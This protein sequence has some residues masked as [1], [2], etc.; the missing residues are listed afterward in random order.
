MELIGITFIDCKPYLTQ[1]LF[2]IIVFILT[3][4]VLILIKKPVVKLIIATIL[5]LFQA[6]MNIGFVFLFDSNGTFFEWSMFNQRNDAFGTVEDLSLRPELIIFCSCVVIAFL[7][8][9]ILIT[10]LK[11]PKKYKYKPKKVRA[12]ITTILLILCSASTIAIPTIEAFRYSKMNYVDR[13]LYGDATNRYQQVG[14]TSNAIYELI[15][16]TMIDGLIKH[17]SKGIENFIYENNQPLLQNSEY[18]GISKNNNLVYILVES[19][20]WYVFLNKCTPEQSA[21]LYPNINKFLSESVYANNFYAREKT[22]TS[23]LLSILGSN[24]T[25]KFTNYDFPK[26]S[27]PWSLPNLFRKNIISNGNEVVQ[28]KSF[29]QN[30]GD[31][32][33]RNTLHESLGFD[34]LVDISDMSKLGVVNTWNDDSIHERNLDSETV[35]IMQNEMFPQTED[36][37]QYMTFWL[38]FGMHGFYQERELFK[39]QGYY[40]KLDE[41]GAYPAGISKKADYLRTY[42]AAVMDFDKALGIIFDKLESN[43]DLDNTT[44]VLFSDHNTYYNNLSYY[45]KDIKERHNSELYRIPFMI[46]DTK[47]KNQYVTNEGNNVISKFTTTSDMIA[48]IFDLF[49]IKAY[50]NLYYGTSMFIKDVESIIF[51]RAYGIFINDKLICYGANNLIY[52]SNNYKK[53]DYNKFI[54]NAEAL[55]NKQEYL[56]K[57][58]FNNYF[59]KHNLREIV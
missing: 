49:G 55:L 51:S 15:N 8:F 29:H 50:R 9:S 54:K 30:N 16:G 43:G 46:Y 28:I 44:I 13:Y 21:I 10:V 19:F 58:Y 38:T 1:P 48:T 40:D 20:E 3:I 59:A 2:P 18:F 39:Q 22:D 57:I 45:A 53:E 4:C 36:N 47:L 56:D 7:I 12:I 23:E 41:V 11:Y 17:N 24:P 25:E 31:F 35:R 34:E 5:L 33:N 14:I 32:Y 37:E 26:N 52:K 6:G 27:Y 42:A